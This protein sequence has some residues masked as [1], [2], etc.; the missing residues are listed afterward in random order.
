MHCSSYEFKSVG[1]FLGTGRIADQF[2]EFKSYE[3]AKKYAQSLKLKGRTEWRA[4]TKRKDFLRDVP[5]TPSEVYR[6]KW[7]GWGEFLGTGNTSNRKVTKAKRFNFE[8][9][10]K[11]AQSL[12]L[13]NEQQWI[14]HTKLEEFPKDIVVAPDKKYKKEWKGWGDFLGTSTKPRSRKS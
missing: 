6:V 2:K 7:E 9:D 11:Y 10:K 12:Q 14:N 5:V 13:T 1:E 8:L 4:Y 3:D